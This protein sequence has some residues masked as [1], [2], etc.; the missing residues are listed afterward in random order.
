MS[1]LGGWNSAAKR[2]TAHYGSLYGRTRTEVLHAQLRQHLPAPPANIVDVGGGSGEQSFLLARSGYQLTIVDPS[3]VMLAE[4]AQVLRRDPEL[5]ANVSLLEGSL[6]TVVQ[7]LGAGTFDGVLCHGVLPF[8]ETPSQALVTLRDLARPGGTISLVAK[9]RR[10]Q[11]ARPALA[12]NWSEALKAFDATVEVNSLGLRSRGDTVEELTE[13]LSVRGVKVQAWYGVRL[14][15]EVWG[16]EQ[17]ASE[18][19]PEMLAVELQASVRDPYRQL[20]RL[21]HLVG[22]RL[23]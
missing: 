10:A 23:E 3:T 2:F 5:R 18:L 12:R 21:F 14:F 11:A 8:L 9:N 7:T 1:D 20:S 6:A 13:I 16:E 17:P 22:K 15:T 19:T 4:A